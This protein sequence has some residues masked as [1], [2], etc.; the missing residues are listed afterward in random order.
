MTNNSAYGRF[1]RVNNTRH[2]ACPTDSIRYMVMQNGLFLRKKIAILEDQI[3]GNSEAHHG[4]LNGS[5]VIKSKINNEVTIKKLVL[6]FESST[7]KT[8]REDRCCS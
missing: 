7:T 1:G 6:Q 3:G 8:V 2:E 4:D 5:I